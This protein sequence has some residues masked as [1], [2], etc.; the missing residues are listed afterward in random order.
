MSVLSKSLFIALRLLFLSK[1]DFLLLS[2]F[3]FV[4]ETQTQTVITFGRC[5][6][7]NFHERAVAIAQHFREQKQS[8]EAN[9]PDSFDL[10]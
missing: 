9:V 10:K 5:L 7:S 8:K 6:A 2:P 4:T 3:A 1:K